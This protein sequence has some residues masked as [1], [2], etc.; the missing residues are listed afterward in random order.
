M[1]AITGNIFNIKRYA[2][3]DGPNIR[4]TIFFKGCSLSCWWCHNPEGKESAVQFTQNPRLSFES[5]DEQMVPLG[6]WT[7]SVPELMEEILK[8]KPF[9]EQSSGGVTCSGGDPL[10]QPDFLLELLKTCGAEGIHRAVDTAAYT[11]SEIIQMIAPETDLWLVDLKH[12]DD[13][14]HEQ[15]TGVSNKMILENIKLLDSLRAEVRIRIPL[16]PGI[17]DDDSN[18][19]ASAEFIGSLEHINTVDILPYHETAIS[20]YRKLGLDYPRKP[21]ATEQSLT[22]EQAKDLMGLHKL[23]AHI[24]G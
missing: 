22:P 4:T 11:T 18:L 9:F 5:E 2:I 14:I 23:S 19:G 20:K 16:I 13:T 15:H 10:Y 24:G 3:H 12:M 7:T 1:R 21:R 17:N 6:G 8:D